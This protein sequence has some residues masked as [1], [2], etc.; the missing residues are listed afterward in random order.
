LAE[1]EKQ[2]EDK[3]LLEPSGSVSMKKMFSEMTKQV[4]DE[5]AG[6]SENLNR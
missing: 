5:R 4:L 1:M 3:E 6:L 2:P